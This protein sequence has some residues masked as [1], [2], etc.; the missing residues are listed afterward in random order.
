MREEI[1]EILRK[2]I[3]IPSP[4]GEE[5]RICLEVE[6]ILK[7]M[8]F[9]LMRQEVRPRAYNLI[10]KRGESPLLIS[11]HLDT[12]HP[13]GH[14]NPFELLEEDGDYIGR[15]VVD[16]KGQLASLLVALKHSKGACQL[17]L[18]VDEEGDGKGSEVLEIEAEEA[19]VLEPT[20]FELCLS[21]AGSL[22]YEI[23]VKGRATHS[24]TPE[25][26]ENAILKAFSLYQELH[27]L[28]IMSARHPLFPPPA[29]ILTKIEGGDFITLVPSSCK[30]QVDIHIL[31]NVEIGKAREEIEGFLSSKGVSYRLIDVAHPFEISETPKICDIIGEFMEKKGKEKRFGGMRSW[32]DAANLIR[33]GIKPV[34]FGA[35]D[36]AIAHSQREWVRADDLLF[37]T[38]VLIH[39]IDNY[40]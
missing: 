31:P 8:G 26:G 22:E 13:Y 25:R 21:E 11:T 35:G 36:L 16:A 34:V 7:S 12:V 30:I 6:G 23:E 32:T 20:N 2:L 3:V 24:A 40:K 38:E 18:T 33:K 14:P 39:L 37:L 27:S 19:L 29:I 10:A 1:R 17:A 28:S 4:T 5:E 15:G 9:S